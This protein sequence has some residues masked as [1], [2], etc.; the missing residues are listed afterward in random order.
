MMKLSDL[1]AAESY[2]RDLARLRH[3]RR[4]LNE[5]K[6]IEPSQVKLY[7]GD[8]DLLVIDLIES[9]F[10]DV[11]CEQFV[12]LLR[13]ALDRRISKLEALLRELGV[14]P[15]DMPPRELSPDEKFYKD[16]PEQFA[17]AHF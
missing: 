15:D 3:A 14:D 5:K 17:P 7:G 2:G 1:K 13:Q 9:P 6:G 16:A 11:E 10:T 12:R 8:Y 4:W